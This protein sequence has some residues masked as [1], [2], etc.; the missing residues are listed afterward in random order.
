VVLVWRDVQF[1][2]P[3]ALALLPL[4]VALA[5]LYRA[6]RPD[7][8]TTGVV[9]STLAPLDRGR[10]GLRLRLRPLLPLLRLLA[11]ALL[12]VALARPRTVEARARFETE[13]IDIVL[14]LDI[15]GSMREPGLEAPSKMEAAKKA[16]VQFLQTRTDDRVGLVVFKSEA[17]VMSPLTTDYKAL[18]EL[19]E[20][21]DKLNEQ[22]LPEGTGIGVGLADALNL[23][24]GSRAKSRVVIL[25]TD[26][27]NNQHKIEPEQ[28]GRIAEA[29]KVRVYTIGIP[30][31]NARADVT[32]NERQM[33]QIAESTGGS[34]TRA[35]NAQ[36]LADTYNS[37][38]ALEKSRIA[39]EG[40]ARY[41]ELAPWLLVPA[42]ALI[43]LEVLLGATV[44]RRAP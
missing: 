36:G 24:R 43:V 44:F 18:V 33:R 38:A 6:R 27:E 41:R 11:L 21:A 29:L 23:L 8:L 10:P 14:V 40:L 12:I 7:R 20:Q 2:D 28:A 34:Y 1:A 15:S 31:A 3:W 39:R 26:G 37:I 22:S 32:L 13:G 4:V 25:A 30:T 17:R 16:L 42:F 19:V 5:V 35:G 9:L